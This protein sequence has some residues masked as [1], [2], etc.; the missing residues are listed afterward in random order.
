MNRKL[1][2]SIALACIGINSAMPVFGEDIDIYTMPPTPQAAPNV[3]LLLD[4]SSN[5]SAADQAWDREEVKAKCNGNKDCERYV[6]LVFG[7]NLKL[8]QGQVEVRALRVVLNDLACTVTTGYR[9]TNVGLMLFNDAGT[10]DSTSG[11]AGYIRQRIQ[12]LAPSSYG[13]TDPKGIISNLATIDSE[14]RSPDYKVPSSIDYGS[15]YYEAF[16][17]FG[18]YANTNGTEATKMGSPPGRTG[19]GPAPYS[20]R[21]SLEDVTAFTSTGKTEYA[22]PI[23][24]ESCANN[25]IVL[26]GNQFPNLEPNTDTRTTPPTNEMM[27][28]LGLRP[29]QLSSAATSGREMRFADEWAQ[30]LARTDVSAVAGHQPVKTFTINVFNR[31]GEDPAQTALLNSMAT[32]GGSGVGGAFKVNGD[33]MA[34]VEGLK[35]IFLQINAVNSSF[36]SASLPI[37][38]NTQGTYLNQVFI[39][40]FRPDV[41]SRPRW[42]GNLKQYQFALQQVPVGEV[43]KRSLFLADANGD[44]AIDNANTGFLQ[45]CARS[46]WTSDS[47]NY[48][49]PITEP[50]PDTPNFGIPEGSCTDYEANDSPDGRV[51]E[52]GGAGQKIRKISPATSRQIATC[53]AAPSN[54]TTSTSF[55]V[56][57]DMEKWIRGDNVGD[58]YNTKTETFYTK[59]DPFA[60]AIRPTVHGGVVHSRPL[61][62]NYGSSDSDDVVVFYGADD[63]LF[64]A[65]DG[66]KDEAASDSGTELWAFLAPEFEE[67]LTRARDNYPFVTFK[68]DPTSPKD[69][70]F[71]GSIGAYIGP[72]NADGTGV[73]VTYILPSMRRGGKM[74]YAF[75]ATAHPGE[76]A[77]VPLWRFGCDQSGNCFGDDSAKLGQTWSTPRIVRVKNQ[78]ALYAVF[79]AGYDPCEDGEPRD[80]SASTTGRGIFVLDA[81]SGE[82]LRYISFGDSS[83]RIASDVV[84][85][86]TNDDGFSDVLYAADTSGNLWRVNLS[87]PEKA[88]TQTPADWTVTRVATIGD[89]SS[90]NNRNR[91]FLYAPDVVRFGIYN[92]ILIGSGN[93]EKPLY[94]PLVDSSKT[95]IAAKT[96]NRFYGFWDEF[97]RT[98]DFVTI[99]DQNDCD[100]AGDTELSTSSCQLMNT[101][102][103][104]KD[105]LPV[106]QSIATRPRGWVIDLTDTT[107]TGPNEQVVTTP[108][109]VGGLVNFSTFQA[110]N[111]SK[112]SALGTARGYAACFL[113]GGASCDAPSPEGTTRSEEFVGGGLPPSPVTGTVLVD[114]K[115]VPFII[116]G[117]PEAGGGSALEVKLP[118][119]PIRKDRTKVYR[120]KKID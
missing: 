81:T 47:S 72:K 71:D 112:C 80:C 73:R 26:V 107:T 45:A 15:A 52:R 70:F 91:K 93:R 75:D 60:G 21:T 63:G 99:N 95:Y 92:I 33:L 32:N 44:P 101:T 55:A 36:A 79:G 89:W 105:Y 49:E 120:Y 67:R 30:F 14:L 82:R 87:N 106:F 25:Y 51:V 104:T 100:V 116:G 66:S 62:I 17:Y 114:G 35:T 10:A 38:V 37:S 83:G 85:V 58:G 59:Y 74:I 48:W 61:A 1:S 77:P 94:D 8:V 34:L 84:P 13:C 31:K 24:L 11:V 56:S 65:I 46:F 115:I 53:A 23:P 9:P 76:K 78:T 3:L 7:D 42:A 109:T 110:K 111:K 40:M 69:F 103:T 4:N 64:R 6:G 27:T 18:G 28:R 113:H 119:I 43:I 5:W 118:P 96:L 19:F 108:A 20:N 2:L 54:C 29:K 50:K 16:K 90:A 102:D 39:G 98:S 97:A 86:D 12:L 22:S 57:T 41:G 117:K 68:D 88:G